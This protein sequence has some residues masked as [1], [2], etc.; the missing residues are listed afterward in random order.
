MSR[1]A[2]PVDQPIKAGEAIDGFHELYPRQIAGHEYRVLSLRNDGNTAHRVDTEELSCTCRDAEY[3]VEEPEVC[4]HLAIALYQAP[5]RI[6][7]EDTA[8]F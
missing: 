5:S 7:V 3:N 2:E 1:Q 4:D 8:P 6:S